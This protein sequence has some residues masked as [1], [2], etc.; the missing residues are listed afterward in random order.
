MG[1]GVLPDGLLRQRVPRAVD[2][3]PQGEAQGQGAGGGEELPRVQL[4]EIETEKNTQTGKQRLVFGGEF[5]LL[6]A[7][8]LLQPAT[9]IRLKN[10]WDVF[11]IWLA[12]LL[13]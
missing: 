10:L 7:A 2:A 5:L 1:G 6:G 11:E 9:R 12:L 3:Q 4:R 8:H 13:E